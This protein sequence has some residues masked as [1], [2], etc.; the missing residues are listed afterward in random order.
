MSGKVAFF[1]RLGPEVSLEASQKPEEKHWGLIK[2]TGGYRNKG[3]RLELLDKALSLLQS[4]KVCLTNLKV[5]SASVTK[6]M[7]ANY[8][9]KEAQKDVGPTG[10]HHCDK[11]GK[12]NVLLLG[13]SEGSEFLGMERLFRGSTKALISNYF[14]S[15][16]LYII[17]FI[18]VF[19]LVMYR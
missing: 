10:L 17:H 2:K 9:R 6:E 15:N 5:S 14:N 7:E 11:G 19:N 12:G 4:G 16:T 13:D 1:D 3:K 8:L 18:S